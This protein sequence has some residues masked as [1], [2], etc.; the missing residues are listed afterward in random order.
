MENGS[1][2]PSALS[3][4]LNTLQGTSFNSF[5]ISPS[6]G[7]SNVKAGGEIRFQLPNVGL[8]DFK[9]S[10][11][12]FSVT[13][14]AAKGARLPAH[15]DTLFSNLTIKA[16]GISLYNGNNFHHIIENVKYNMGVKHADGVTG[17]KDCLDAGN[18]EGASLHADNVS[19]TYAGLGAANNVFSVDLGDMAK[20]SPR[21]LDLSILPA[22]EICLRVNDDNCLSSIHSGIGGRGATGG[23]TTIAD[24]TGAELSIVNPKFYCQMYSLASS[25]Y[26]QAIRARM[27]DVGYLSICYDSHLVFNSAFTGSSRFSLSAMSLKRLSAVFRRSSATT[28]GPFVPIVGGATETIDGDD[29]AVYGMLGSS[30]LA[31]S[32]VNEYQ[33]AVQS[34]CL[35]T[36]APAHNADQNK[37]AFGLYNATTPCN[38]QFKIQSASVPQ[39]FADVAQMAELTKSAYNV[40]EFAKAKILP[41]YLANYFTFAIPLNLP[42][43]PSEKKIISGLSTQST[44]CFVELTSNGANVKTDGSYEVLV[45]ATLDTILRVGEGKSIEVLM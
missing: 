32:G 38:L 36:V 6:T 20:L 35:P 40:E 29:G 9:T 24:S 16:G 45:L 11:M 31:K 41:Q 43:S 4:S 39:Y 7:A 5:E 44:N 18:Q 3:Y 37:A 17:H 8:M 26:A 19:E 2:I 23:A 22:L 12:T 10:K 13:T 15:T 1:G 28:L 21:L 27:A 25:A 33:G 42:E 34:F 14:T 30:R